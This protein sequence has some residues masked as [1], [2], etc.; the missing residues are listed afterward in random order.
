M[1]PKLISQPPQNL[2]KVALP[3]V[4]IKRNLT[5]G[6]KT[7]IPGNRAETSVIRVKIAKTGSLEARHEPYKRPLMGS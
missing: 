2:L 6:P 5:L 7:G 4:V 3:T 1:T